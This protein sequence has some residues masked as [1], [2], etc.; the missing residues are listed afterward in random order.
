[1]RLE[2][3][4]HAFPGEY[5]D[6]VRFLEGIFAIQRASGERQRRQE[7]ADASDLRD[8]EPAEDGT[9]VVGH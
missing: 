2:P 7:E 1:V 8:E 9:E 4:V 5:H 6:G 3:A